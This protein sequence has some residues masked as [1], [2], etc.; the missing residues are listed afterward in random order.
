MILKRICQPVLTVFTHQSSCAFNL[1]FPSFYIQ[2]GRFYESNQNPSFHCHADR[3][4][5]RRFQCNS[6]A[7]CVLHTD[8]SCGDHCEYPDHPPDRRQ[9]RPKYHHPDHQR[10]HRVPLYP[11]LRILYLS[12]DRID[13][14]DII[15]GWKIKIHAC[16]CSI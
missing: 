10:D 13:L 1:N 11:R 9:R 3:C 12:H 7:N 2:R 5:S 6:V 14:R 4:R 16:D 15:A 8:H